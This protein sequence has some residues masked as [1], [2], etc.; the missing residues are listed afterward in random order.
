MTGKATMS[1]K[2]SFG[3]KVFPEDLEFIND[4]LNK[5]SEYTEIKQKCDAVMYVFNQYVALKYPS[6]STETLEP[7]EIITPEIM[8]R[9][10]ALESIC[11]RRLLTVINNV[12]YCGQSTFP[13][14]IG[15][16]KP[17]IYA[18]KTLPKYGQVMSLSDI[19]RACEMCKQSYAESGRLKDLV[20]ALTK[21]LNEDREANLYFCNHPD[22]M[23]EMFTAFPL[24]KFFCATSMRNV[25]IASTCLKNECVNL[26]I[27]KVQFPPRTIEES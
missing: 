4:V 1:S 14:G 20:D 27:V 8:K 17:F 7:D 16:L 12:P 9:N 3:V 25:T 5:A 24:A 13:K 26:E 19:E 6:D 2:V 22:I 23:N 21:E 18:E 10:K 11:E 15:A